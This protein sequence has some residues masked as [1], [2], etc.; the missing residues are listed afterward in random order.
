MARLTLPNYSRRR[1]VREM[2][3][4]ANPTTLEAAPTQTRRELDFAL[5]GEL[6]RDGRMPFTTL[7][8]RIGISEAQVRRRTKNLLDA[9]VFAI[10]PI[11]NPRVVGL[12]A[13]ACIGLVVRGPYVAT[14]SERLLAIPEVSFVV[15]TSGE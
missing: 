8:A 12:D 4:P 9:D 13:L 14:V 5:F 3:Q 2:P 6:Q 15:V 7:A 10:V 11:A 1:V